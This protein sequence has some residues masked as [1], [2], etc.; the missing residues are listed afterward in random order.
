MAATSFALVVGVGKRESVCAPVQRSGLKMWVQSLFFKR[1][2]H[3]ILFHRILFGLP[4]LNLLRF[5][6]FINASIFISID[7]PYTFSP[8]DAEINSFASK[9]AS[10]SSF[11]SSWEVDWLELVV[12]GETGLQHSRWCLSELLIFSPSIWQEKSQVF[13]FPKRFLLNFLFGVFHIDFT[14]IFFRGFIV[15]IR[16]REWVLWLFDLI[17]ELSTQ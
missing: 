13:S 9:F 6:Y 4:W 3:H 8:H 7:P 17:A 14:W 2:I 12:E 11:I 10:F 1:D 15:V 5:W 16:I